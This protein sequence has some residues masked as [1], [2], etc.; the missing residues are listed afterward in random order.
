MLPRPTRE[1]LDESFLAAFPAPSLETLFGDAIQLRLPPGG[2][3]YRAGDEPRAGLVVAGLFRVFMESPAGKQVTVRYARRGDVLGVAA[4]VGGPPPVSVQSL[5]ESEIWMVS[6]PRLLA[7]GE[8]DAAIAMALARELT[9]RLYDTL[10]ELAGHAF[11]SVRQRVARHLLDLAA[12]DQRGAS[13]LVASVTHQDLADA[14]G[15][16]RE[17]ITRVLGE[18]RRAGL[19]GAWEGGGIALLDP[20][21]MHRAA[22]GE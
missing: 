2:S 8:R 20:A 21:A 22:L 11:A 3:I 7:L 15:S 10:D 9:E 5:T 6:V 19:V 12:R 13:A 1:A 17:V 14:I 16:S 18:M 4:A